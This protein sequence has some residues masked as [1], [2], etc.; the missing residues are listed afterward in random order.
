MQQEISEKSTSPLKKTES[1]PVDK[2][3]CPKKKYL[4]PYRNVL[5]NNLNRVIEKLDFNGEP[6]LRGSFNYMEV[7]LPKE[8]LESINAFYP[9]LVGILNAFYAC[10][11]P[12]R[13]ALI[14]MSNDIYTNYAP[15][16]A[17]VPHSDQRTKSYVKIDGIINKILKEKPS[18]FNGRKRKALTIVWNPD[19][20]FEG[21]EKKEVFQK[22]RGENKK[23]HTLS[24]LKEAYKKGMTQSQLGKSV[25]MSRSTIKRYWKKITL[26]FD[27]G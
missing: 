20:G 16:T 5:C 15:F 21:Q 26:D 9:V 11:S 24:I 3:N 13:E 1:L 19:Y 18:T 27:G 10:E 25:N 8:R 4:K 14:A 17:L 6:F 2:P 7:V 23:E 22:I 12:T